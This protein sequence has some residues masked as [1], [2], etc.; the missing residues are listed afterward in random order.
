MFLEGRTALV[1]GASRGIGREIALELAREGADVIVNHLD[2]AVEAEGVCAEIARLGRRALSLRADVG[3]SI[4]ADRMMQ[5][6]AANFS[7]L[8]ILVNNAGIQTW[9]PSCSI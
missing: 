1:T 7:R 3:A 2:D 6:A 9:K 8:D 5:E 4:D